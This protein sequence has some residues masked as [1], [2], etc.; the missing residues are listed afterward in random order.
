M[1]FRCVCGPRVS[2]RMVDLRL[3]VSPLLA[4]SWILPFLV[5]TTALCAQH[6]N[7]VSVVF[8]VVAVDSFCFPFN[9]PSVAVV[10]LAFGTGWNVSSGKAVKRMEPGT[11]RRQLRRHRC[12]H[13]G[14]RELPKRFCQW[15]LLE[16]QR[17]HPLAAVRSVLLPPIG[18]CDA[19]V[20][21]ACMAG[22]NVSSGRAGKRMETKLV[23]Q[24]TRKQRCCHD[25]A[26]G[27]MQSLPENQ[28][29]HSME[30]QE[31]SFPFPFNAPSDAVVAPAFTS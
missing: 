1:C 29:R 19:V 14:S 24:Q 13:E 28:R 2:L 15:S 27:S 23:P 26:Y 6:T 22:P 7:V 4:L 9:V 31:G 30:A 21:L 10:A 25:G 20:A 8:P 17:R 3:F 5:C 12:C 18:C 16:Y 11:G